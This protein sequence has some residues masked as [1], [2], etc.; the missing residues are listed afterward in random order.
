MKLLQVDW[1]IQELSEREAI[2]WNSL[3][4]WLSL[5]DS[6]A[7]RAALIYFTPT[8]YKTEKLT[9]IS[10]KKAIFMLFYFMIWSEDELPSKTLN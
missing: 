6:F 8:K 9:K 1:M 2:H 4:H 10:Y 5:G 3:N 7:R